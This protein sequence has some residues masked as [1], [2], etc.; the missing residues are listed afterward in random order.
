MFGLLLFRDYCSHIGVEKPLAHYNRVF[1]ALVGEALDEHGRVEDELDL[2]LKNLRL[3]AED[4]TIKRRQHYW[5]EKV[6]SFR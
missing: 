4:N 6:V 2:F 3:L 5:L 1:R